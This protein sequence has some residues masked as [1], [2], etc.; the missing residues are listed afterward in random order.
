[1]AKTEQ[2]PNNCVNCINFKGFSERVNPLK[3]FGKCPTREGIIRSDLA[4]LKCSDFKS[5]AERSSLSR[6]A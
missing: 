3:V 4:A 6:V 5:E 1:M 2:V